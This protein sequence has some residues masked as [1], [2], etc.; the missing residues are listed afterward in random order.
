MKLENIL[1]I[2]LISISLFSSNILLASIIEQCQLPMRH[3]V[4]SELLDPLSAPPVNTDGP[5][6]QTRGE[7]TATVNN[8]ETYTTSLGNTY[9]LTVA[10]SATCTITG[11][12]RLASAIVFAGASSG[13]VLTL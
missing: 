5:V 1:K 6:P 2:C 9:N 13:S 4:S 10:S 7:I 3:G 11:N 8:L 12:G